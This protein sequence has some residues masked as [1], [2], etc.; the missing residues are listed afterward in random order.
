M[1]PVHKRPNAEAVRIADFV[2]RDDPGTEWRMRVEGFAEH[3]L[4][5]AELPVAHADVVAR[6]IAEDDARRVLLRHVTAALADDDDELGLVIDLRGSLG[7]LDRIEG[8]VDGIDELGKPHLVLGRLSAR[9]GDVVGIIEADGKDLL[10]LRNRRQ[11]M[12]ACDLEL[13]LCRPGERTQPV[14]DPRPDGDHAGHAP[15]EIGGGLRQIDQ[16]VAG[17]DA[18]AAFAPYF[19]TRQFHRRASPLTAV[20]ER[21]CCDPLSA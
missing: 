2:G 14:L 10:R 9:F 20:E 16:P 6:A 8:T 5:R 17:D 11:Q 21:K 18:D 4:R 15:R 3:V 7:Q 19:K 1:S 13:R 12:H